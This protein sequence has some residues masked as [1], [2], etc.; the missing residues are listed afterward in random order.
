MQL[1]ILPTSLVGDALSQVFFRELSVA[2]G[3]N[4]YEKSIAIKSA[5]ISFY[6]SCSAAAFFILGGDKIVQIFL[7]EKWDNTGPMVLCMS[8]FAFPTIISEALMSIFKVYNRQATR[9]KYVSVN[10]TI[11][12]V[13]LTLGVLL[14]NNIL[15][16]LVL[17]ALGRAIVRFFQLFEELK[18]VGLKFRAIHRHFTL[19]VVVLYLLLSV[20]IIVSMCG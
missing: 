9:L 11:I 15:Y 13:S 4:G 20:R 1:I 3:D 16:V 8:I 2:V 12:I 14:F 18:I 7:G 10:L 6:L 5:K 17:Y 19:I